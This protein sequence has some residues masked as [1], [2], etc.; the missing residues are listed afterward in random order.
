MNK[1]QL[2][3][4]TILCLLTVLSWGGQFPI[5]R[6][7]LKQIDP[8][9]F[10]AIR[11]TAAT[12]IFLLL[13]LLFEGKKSLKVEGNLLLLW[14]YGTIGFVGFNFLMFSGQ[15]MAGDTGA[16]LASIVLGL[17]PLISLII[18]STAKKKR[19]NSIVLLSIFFSLIGTLLVV[20]KG[21]PEAFL[22]AGNNVVPMLWMLIGVICWVFYTLGANKFSGWS[23][24]R[25][26]T[27]SCVLGAISIN[28]IV[29]AFSLFGILELPTLTLVKNVGL[30][31]G[32]MIL[33][34]GVL[35]VFCWNAG[36]KAL[37]P[38]NGILFINLVP[39]TTITISVIQGYQIS[40]IEIVGTL[41]IISS[42]IMNNLYQRK[43]LQ[44][45]KTNLNEP[46]VVKKA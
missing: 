10:T 43:M 26:T 12:L 15:K 27:W 36:N 18:I 30:E 35:A 21:D 3:K 45:N 16:L 5:M 8:F 6:S 25:Y 23:P 1:N 29:L 46:I 41:I 19:P 39:I 4:G 14:F 7:A 17:M 34:A 37:T 20:T 31:L 11:Y 13:L 2:I 44:D 42:L 33:F 32:Y 9:S 22:S 40:S 24:L 38:T 28:L